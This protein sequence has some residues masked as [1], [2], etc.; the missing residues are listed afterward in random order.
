M[1][2]LIVNEWQCT[3]KPKIAS[4]ALKLTV[5]SGVLLVGGA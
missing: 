2:D 5:Y 1:R 4:Q 3:D